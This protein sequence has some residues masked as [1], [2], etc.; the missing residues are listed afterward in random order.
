MFRIKVRF[1]DLLDRLVKLDL[2]VGDTAFQV[3]EAPRVNERYILLPPQTSQDEVG[4]E[5]ARL[6]ERYFRRCRLRRWLLVSKERHLLPIMELPQIR[7]RSFAHP[8]SIRPAWTSITS[9]L[10]KPTADR[11]LAEAEGAVF[12]SKSPGSFFSGFLRSSFIRS[13]IS[14]SDFSIRKRYSFT[15]F[16]SLGS[17]L[18]IPAS[19]LPS[20]QR[21]RRPRISS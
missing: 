5:I 12:K 7:A 13:W 21:R 18:G 9:L 17:G 2:R 10:S 6:E 4:M 16:G 19:A 3:A 8:R 15:M 1:L 11:V 14:V 20:A